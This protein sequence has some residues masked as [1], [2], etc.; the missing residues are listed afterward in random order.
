MK[1]IED[2]F[3]SIADSIR[4][5]KGTTD[6]IG[7]CD[8]EKEILSIG[9]G[10]VEVIPDGY[11]K[12]QG[13]KSIIENGKHD[14]TNYMYVQVDVPVGEVIPEGSLVPEGTKVVTANG[15][16]DIKEYA[17]LNVNVP[18]PEGYILPTGT[19]I[20]T[21]NG[22]YE[23]EEFDKVTVNVP[24]PD[25]YILPEGTKVITANGTHY[26]D[27]AYTVEVKVPV[28]NGYVIPAGTKSVTANG[29]YDVKEFA[30]V[31]VAVPSD[32]KE[33]QEKIAIPKDEAQLITA[34][35]PATQTLKSVLV[36]G[37]PS[38]YYKPNGTKSVTFNGTYDVKEYANVEVAV[39]S[40]AKEEQTKFIIP[41]KDEHFIRADDP[42]TQTL[43]Y[44]HVHPIPSEYIIPEGTATIT[45]NGK[46]YIRDYEYV[47]VNVDKAKSEQIKDV[48]PSEETQTITADDPSFQTLREVT[49]WPIPSEYIKPNF[50]EK[51]VKSLDG[52]TAT[53]VPDEGYNGLSKVNINLATSGLVK[54][55]GTLEVTEVGNHY[56]AGKEYVN[57]THPDSLDITSNGTHNVANYGSVNVNIAGE[58]CNI[59][60]TEFTIIPVPNSGYVEK[61]YF[62]SNL[63]V[64]EVV[65]ILSTLPYYQT[66]FLTSPI[67]PILFSATGSPVVFA[68][69][70]DTGAGIVYEINIAYDLANGVYDRIFLSYEA[71]V[72]AGF[73]KSE[74]EIN[75]SVIN[76]YSEIAIGIKNDKITDL[77]WTHEELS[78]EVITLAG[79]YNGVIL[80]I[81]NNGK[82]KLKELCFDNKEVPTSVSVNVPT[83][84]G[85]KLNPIM[86]EGFSYKFKGI[87]TAPNTSA[88]NSHYTLNEE[89][90]SMVK[91]LAMFIDVDI[92]DM[93]NMAIM[94]SSYI[95][96]RPYESDLT[97]NNKGD[98]E[99]E[100][101][102]GNTYM[103]AK[104]TLY[105]PPELITRMLKEYCVQARFELVTAGTTAGEAYYMV[106]DSS[107]STYMSVVGNYYPVTVKTGLGFV[108]GNI[109]ASQLVYNE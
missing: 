23:I 42:E 52:F 58:A 101:T 83:I 22:T 63:T 40:D 43:S 109:Y 65:N 73:Y 59:S 48:T 17:E 100:D 102:L 39:P 16:Y 96:F 6:P 91:E 66:P 2:K 24:V 20:I 79:N 11:V 3:C 76:N 75:S 29:S 19:K 72:S 64:D 108:E 34:D 12:V 61:V 37:I 92:S 80:D 95:T 78:N 81:S 31:T 30:N 89:L 4:K 36:Y 27:G 67:Y 5:R 49:V 77:V 25:G 44:V 93:S 21:S 70:V 53:V 99:N 50:Q 56:V 54:P 8:F 97:F 104:R 106:P 33:E 85:I 74:C 51:T 105:I 10:T 107:Y 38:E 9:D 41:D 14:V 98:F 35:D 32:A 55:S 60:N 15:T 28:P 68:V 71:E 57:I 18:I 45:N 103:L 7:C 87:Y 86:P 46:Q 88:Q 1:R 69:Q 62:N 82:Y 47:E 94:D 13:T 90:T 84:Q 26:V